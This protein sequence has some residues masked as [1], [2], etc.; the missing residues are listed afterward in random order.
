LSRDFGAEHDLVAFV[1]ERLADNFF[2]TSLAVERRV[3]E[4][5]AEVYGVVD[6][7]DAHGLVVLGAK[8]RP[9]TDAG[10][11]DAGLTEFSVFHI[12]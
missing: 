9:Q 3:D 11:F 5:A 12:V 10:H 1:F 2:R 8:G 4:G 7:A 6:D